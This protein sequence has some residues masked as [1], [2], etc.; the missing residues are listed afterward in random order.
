MI[1]LDAITASLVGF[2][3]GHLGFRAVKWLMSDRPIRPITILCALITRSNEHTGGKVGIVLIS[4]RAYAVII[5][6]LKRHRAKITRSGAGILISG[7]RVEA[8]PR[9]DDQTLQF[10][11]S[12]EREYDHLRN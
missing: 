1:I 4:P 10:I 11:Y 12:M 5:N 7:M 8:D 3:L 2:I 9:L 6:D